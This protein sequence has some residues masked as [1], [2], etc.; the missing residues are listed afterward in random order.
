LRDGPNP[1][2]TRTAGWTRDLAKLQ[3]V[4]AALSRRRHDPLPQQ[5]MWLHGVVRGY[6]NYHAVPGNMPALETFRREV[7]RSWLRALRRRGQRHRLSWERL[8][9][10]ADRCIPKPKIL[11]PDPGTRFNA[12]H[13][14]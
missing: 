12:K 9:P 2:R 6:F 7:V 11:H 4:K 1:G 3:G 8:G 5:V 10:L 14:R 13:P